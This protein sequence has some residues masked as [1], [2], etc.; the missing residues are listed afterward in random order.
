M[1]LTKSRAVAFLEFG[2]AAPGM[3]QAEDR[4]HRIGQEADSVLAYYLV[5]ED[6]IDEQII[7]VLNKRNK[8]LK[9]VLNDED[10][11]LFEPKK[12]EEFSKLILNEYKNKKKLG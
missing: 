9:R 10:E 2:T 3:E 8:D 12:E 1:T 4:V 11:E 6:S 7:E 5:M